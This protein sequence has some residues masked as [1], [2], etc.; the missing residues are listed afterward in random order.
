MGGNAPSQLPTW[1]PTPLPSTLGTT[2]STLVVVPRVVGVVPGGWG[3]MRPLTSQLGTWRVS[4][5]RTRVRT[6]GA[7]T[8]GRREGPRRT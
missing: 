8:Q 1:Y 4:N 2:P 3:S 7:P 6:P 5:M